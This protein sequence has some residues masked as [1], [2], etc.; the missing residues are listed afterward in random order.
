MS[1]VE[2]LVFASMVVASVAAPHAAVRPGGAEASDRRAKDEE[3]ATARENSA[4]REA[5][6]TAPPLPGEPID[7]GGAPPLPGEPIDAG[8]APPLPGEPID[9]AG[10]PTGATNGPREGETTG[11]ERTEAAQE[12][13]APAVRD[14]LA[15]AARL[16]GAYLHMPDAPPPFPTD[17]D[18]VFS[19]ILRAVGNLDLGR[20]VHTELNI[21]ARFD[22]VPS[23]LFLASAFNT[24]A[25]ISSV[26][27]YPHAA[28]EFWR[29]GTVVGEVAFDRLNGTITA[30]P[31]A[32][33]VGRFAVSH[34]VTELATVNDFF[35]P[36]NTTSLNPMYKPGID[37]MRTTVALG[38]LS[39]IE[40][41]A[42]LGYDGDEPAFR[43]S[44]L[45]GRASVT[46]WNIEWAL[47]GGKVAQRYVAG[48]SLQGD[49]GPIGLR[50]EGHVGVPDRDGDGR[51][52]RG[53]KVHGRVSAGPNVRFDWHA[54][55]LSAEYAFF[56][57]GAKDGADLIPR[58]SRFFPDDLPY[59]GKHYVAFG[60]GM[61]ITP[62]VR[63]APFA[64]VN[65]GDG[66][67]IAGNVL[68]LSLGNES[69]L[70]LGFYAPWGKGVRIVE[71]APLPELRSEFGAAPFVVYLET[72]AYF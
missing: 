33:T 66:S 52:D 34:S 4:D 24:G 39:Q 55:S 57:D 47:L 13:A 21:Y 32:V 36:F 68:S 23:G 48:A 18:A 37:G 10:G 35:A 2:F 7:A 71:G 19:S 62:L 17:D 25:A 20:Y 50:A 28:A 67:G 56:S 46:L 38:S 45:F 27:R 8:R 22:R 1:S 49:V 65:A 31:V 59:L 16:V 51:K 69:D 64:F 26:Y 58:A 61:E 54:L 29:D 44:A 14:R 5:T 11:R 15:G 12:A 72:R 6:P 70:N 53:E 63:T 42:A 41:L 3:A 43:N 9:A 40:V 30:G 60:G